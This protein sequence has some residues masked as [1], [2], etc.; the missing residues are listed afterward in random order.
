M[1]TTLTRAIASTCHDPGD[2]SRRLV[3]RRQALSLNLDD[4]GRRAR[5]DP[6]YLVYL[7]RRADTAPNPATLARLADVLDTSVAALR[8]GGR[9]GVTA[10]TGP[11][12][13]G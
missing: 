6:G 2:L 11:R 12:S 3:H 13:R 1:Q 7:E 10:R 9:L 8:G 4:V 5:I